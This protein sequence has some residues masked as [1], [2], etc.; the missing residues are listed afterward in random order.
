MRC[1]GDRFLENPGY[2]LSERFPKGI[3][4]HART[5]KQ[6]LFN[7][8]YNPSD[9]SGIVLLRLSSQAKPQDLQAAVEIL[10]RG[11]DTAEVAGKLWIIR[12]EKLLEYQSIS[13]DEAD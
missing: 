13:E 2:H 12:G 1:E 7:I 11:L 6:Y 4:S 8:L 3:A 9:Y 10:I 5:Q